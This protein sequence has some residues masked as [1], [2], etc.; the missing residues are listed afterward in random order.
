MAVTLFLGH[1]S[2]PAKGTD[3]GMKKHEADG[4]IRHSD[5]LSERVE[6]VYFSN[7]RN[8]VGHT[9][10]SCMVLVWSGHKCG[11]SPSSKFPVKVI[12]FILLPHSPAIFKICIIWF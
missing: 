9:V 8:I 4:I 5:S 3:K 11:C 12:V 10:P 1:N 7:H 6:K 2:T